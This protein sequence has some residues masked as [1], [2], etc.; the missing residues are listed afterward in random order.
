MRSSDRTSAMIH[1][2]A[3]GEAGERVNRLK[4]REIGMTSTL[5]AH[6][7]F[8]TARARYWPAFDA[9]GSLNPY[10]TTSAARFEAAPGMPETFAISFPAGSVTV[11]STVKGRASLAGLLTG[12]FASTMGFSPT[13]NRGL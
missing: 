2:P 13:T 6:L 12:I 8:T 5:P 4:S 10:G 3:D 1:R 7:I 9:A 11:K